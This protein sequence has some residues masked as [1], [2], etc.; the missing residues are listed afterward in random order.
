MTKRRAVLGICVAC[1]LAIGAISVQSAAAAGTTAFTCKP[2]SGEKDSTDFHCFSH[3]MPGIGSYGHVP[4]AE[5][6]STAV[7]ATGGETRLKATISGINVDIKSTGVTGTGSLINGVNEQGE[8]VINGSGTLT[9]NGVTVVAPAGK[10][11]A[12]A[13]G[14]VEPELLVTRTAGQ[15]MGVEIRQF[16]FEMLAEFE[17]SGCSI[18]ALNGPYEVTGTVVGVPEGATIKFS[19]TA[20][21]AQETLRLRGQKAGLNGSIEIKNTASGT[22]ISPTTV[23]TPE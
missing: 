12:V 19:H 22:P 18:A 8:H 15:G 2:F 7:T 14:K 11:C 6:E 13:G 1:A 10:G 20:T 21:T 4:I 9:F 5:E 16:A 17:V 23:E 3:V